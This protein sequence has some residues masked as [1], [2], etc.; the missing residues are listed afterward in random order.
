VEITKRKPLVLSAQLEMPLT[1]RLIVDLHV[2]I[3]PTADDEPMPVG[4]TER[5]GTPR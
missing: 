2:G 5:A 4:Q 3:R 1:D